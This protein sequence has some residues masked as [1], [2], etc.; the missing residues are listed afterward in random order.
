MAAKFFLRSLHDAT[1][2][3]EGFCWQVCNRCRS[4]AI[5]HMQADILAGASSQHGAY[6][7]LYAEELGLVLE[8]APEDVAEVRSAYEAQGLSAAAIGSTSADKGISIAVGGEASIQGAAAS[9][10][11]LLGR[12]IFMVWQALISPNVS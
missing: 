11:P 1:V 8:V 6:G 3:E 5:F 7:A 12:D 2:Y 4:L 10:I 9:L